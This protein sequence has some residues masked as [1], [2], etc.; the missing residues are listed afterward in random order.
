MIDRKDCAEC[1]HH[2]TFSD[3]MDDG[4]FIPDG[5]ICRVDVGE[6]AWHDRAC[7]SEYG[8]TQDARDCPEFDSMWE[9]A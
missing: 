6:V 2:E 3:E 1:N 4:T 9:V 5:C 7:A 8:G